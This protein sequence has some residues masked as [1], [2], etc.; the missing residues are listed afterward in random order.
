M[1][2]AVFQT[3]KHTDM[4]GRVRTWTQADLDKIIENYNPQKHE[5]PAVIGHP[6]TD[7]P[8]WGWVNSLSRQGD[9]LLAEFKELAPEFEGWL[10][11]GRYKKRSICL[12]PDL[13]LKHVGFLGAT[14][15]AVKGLPDHFFSA[16]PDDIVIELSD[17]KNKETKTMEM[18]WND[19]K[20]LFGFTQQAKPSAPQAENTPQTQAP[21][22]FSEADIEAARKEAA[23]QAAK[24]ERERLTLEFAEKAKADAQASRIE[25]AKKRVGTLI[26]TGKVPPAWAKAGLA[27]FVS[28]LDSATE[29]QFG[30]AADKKTTPQEFFMGLLE[31][32]PQLVTFKEVATRNIDVTGGDPAAKIEALIQGKLAANTALSYA[33]ALTAVQKENME[34]IQ[35]FTEYNRP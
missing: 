16:S 33:E 22:S 14:P 3:G 20:E 24:A 31:D 29:I 19:I 4:N 9:L 5:A 6:K 26:A 34:L 28:S 10:K 12:Y 30:E 25:A 17:H 7:S 15:P 2:I 8:A 23:D 11:D 27:A 21:V 32:L 35:E 18:T 1:K 13:T